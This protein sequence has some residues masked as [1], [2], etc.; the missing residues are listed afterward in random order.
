MRTTALLTLASFGMAFAATQAQGQLQ[1]PT[2][3]RPVSLHY[4]YYTQDDDAAPSPSDVPPP[5]V[6]DAV[7]DAPM[8][9][10]VVPD[11]A[12]GAPVVEHGAVAEDVG[13]GVMAAPADDDYDYECEDEGPV[14]LFNGCGGIDI[15]GHMSFG[16]YGNDNGNRSGIGNAPLGFR[17]VSDGATFDQFW[18]TAE[19]A[20]DDCCPSWGFRID[21]VFGADGPDTTAFGDQSKFDFRWQSSRDYGSALPQAYAQYGTSD[22]N[23]KVGHFYT[24]I[25]YEVVSAPENFFYS[26]AY[27]MYYGEPFTHT[28][29]LAER[30]M[31]CD[32]MT[33]W[34]GWTNGWDSYYG[35]HLD[36]STFLGGASYA[37]ND[38]LSVTYAT[39]W[40]DHGDGTARG[41]VPSNAGDIYMHSVVVDYQINE[42]MQYVFQSDYANNRIAGA[43]NE[44]YGVNQYLFYTLSD[45]YKLGA[46]FEWFNDADGVRIVNNDAVG[47][48]IGPDVDYYSVTLGLNYTPNNNIILRPE[49]RWDWADGG[50]PFNPNAA[51]V[52]TVDDQFYYGMDLIVLF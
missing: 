40:G 50:T 30:S 2:T 14:R 38:C 33:V 13:N 3:A 24:I 34:A 27:T 26:H 20:L 5:P 41:G 32:Q 46:R 19:K 1:P 51:G 22:F 29:I 31:M 7:P 10:T 9:D 8:P 36:A 16:I 4:T 23:V 48:A 11:T 21:Y 43:H 45:C 44:W 6:E 47:T 39:V 28:G 42:C 52:G 18:L 49:V 35:D 25:G 37:V 17:N 12:A 15:Y